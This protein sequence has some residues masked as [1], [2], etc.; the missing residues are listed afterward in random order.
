VHFVVPLDAPRFDMSFRGTLG[1]MP[2]TSFNPFIRE[3]MPLRLTN[4]RVVGISFHATVTDGVARGSVT[5]RYNDLSVAVTQRGSTGIMGLGGII[6]G[7]ARGIA[8]FVGNRMKVRANNPDNTAAAPRSGT[9]RRTFTS[10]ETLP[11]FLW[12]GVRDGLLA[13]VRK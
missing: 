1:A 11:G 8:S 6:G 10:D 9:I 13:V 2:A 7:A 5:P 3:T 4:G 12:A